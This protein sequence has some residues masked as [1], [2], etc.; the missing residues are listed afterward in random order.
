[1]FSF[2]MILSAIIIVISFVKSHHFFKSV[3]L[4]SVYGMIALFAVNFVGG[5]ISLHL[6]INVFSLLVSSF[7]GLPG[8][9]F[10]VAADMISKI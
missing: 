3:F 7:G 8:V 2:I 4:S 1:M 5:F 6:N 10:L 9:I